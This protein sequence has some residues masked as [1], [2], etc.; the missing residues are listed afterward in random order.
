MKNLSIKQRVTLYYAAVFLLITGLVIG[1][2]YAAFGYQTNQVS[3]LSLE[4]AVKNAFDFIETPGDWLEISPDFDFY[5]D[6]VTLLVYGPEGTLMLGHEPQ[7]FP[8]NTA[9]RSDEHQSIDTTLDQW[10][11]Y[12]LYT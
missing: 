8:Q 6:D 5:V 1:G 10:Q 11:V 9:L 7:S 4:R 2:F 12:D 3:Q